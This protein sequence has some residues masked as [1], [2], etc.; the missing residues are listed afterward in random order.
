VLVALLL[1]TRLRSV[2]A[3]KIIIFA[4]LGDPGSC[5]RADLEMDLELRFRHS[6]RT[7]YAVG[8][9]KSY[10]PFLADLFWQR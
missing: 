2:H 8:A 4:A 1:N 7:L 6:E 3:L 10:I 9:I 5:C